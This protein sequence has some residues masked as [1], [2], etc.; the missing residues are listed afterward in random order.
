MIER[1]FRGTR[2]GAAEQGPF[3]RLS[4]YK[5]RNALASWDA[6]RRR[7]G[8]M[9]DP[10]ARSPTPCMYEGYMLWPYR[11]SAMKNQRRWTFG[12][13]F[14]PAWSAAHPDDACLDADAGARARA[15]P[16]VE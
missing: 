1:Y 11:R 15:T 2:V 16:D 12:G 13:V 14:P 6:R 7:S 8:P 5:S 9:S 3:D 10:C 4:A